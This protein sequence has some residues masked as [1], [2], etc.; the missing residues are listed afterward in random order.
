MYYTFPSAVGCLGSWLSRAPIM[1]APVQHEPT[2]HQRPTWSAARRFSRETLSFTSVPPT[3]WW[4][5]VGKVHQEWLVNRKWSKHRELLIGEPPP[6]M[7][8]I[9]FE[10]W[11]IFESIHLLRCRDTLQ[12]WCTFQIALSSIAITVGDI[13]APPGGRSTSYSMRTQAKSLEEKGLSFQI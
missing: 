5:W 3:L 1:G 2:I 13:P 10:Q 4:I 11:V 6:V 9:Y 12:V 8:R 7:K